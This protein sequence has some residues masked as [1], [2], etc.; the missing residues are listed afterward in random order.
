MRSE[1]VFRKVV[2]ESRCC[3]VV[4]ESVVEDGTDDIAKGGVDAG[5]DGEPVPK[6]MS[7]LS[8]R[9]LGNGRAVGVAVATTLEEVE[10]VDD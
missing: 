6:N 4:E 3:W 10:A 8:V 5:D 7:G 1:V 2:V 9:S